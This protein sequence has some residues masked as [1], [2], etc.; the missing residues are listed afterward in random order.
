MDVQAG[1]ALYWWQRQIT[2]GA[3]RIRVKYI[4][5]VILIPA[6][7]DGDE[8]LPLLYRHVSLIWIYPFSIFGTVH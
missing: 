1:L 4:K 6:G 7:T 2:F 8:P 5:Y 3:G